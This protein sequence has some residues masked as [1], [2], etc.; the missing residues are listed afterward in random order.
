MNNKKGLV[1]RI[2][3]SYKDAEGLGDMVA[4]AIN[5]TTGIKPTGD[6]GCTKRK[7][8]LNRWVPFHKRK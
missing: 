4:D 8:K 7:E 2:A 5:A 3:Q 1:A 6:C